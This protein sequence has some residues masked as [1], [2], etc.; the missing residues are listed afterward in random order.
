MS[1]YALTIF[2]SVTSVLALPVLPGE[3]VPFSPA[4]PGDVRSPC[5]LLNAIANHGF[6]PHD[7]KNIDLT[8]ML[9]GIDNAVGLQAT[10]RTFFANSFNRIA[11]VSSTGKNTTINLNDLSVHNVIE[12]DG[13]LS[14]LDIAQ[15]DHVSFSQTTF[16]ET[17]S[18]WPAEKISIKD[19]GTAVKRRQQTQTRANPQYNLSPALLNTTVAQS[20]LYLGLFGNF[21]D[22]NADKAQTVF[23]FGTV[24]LSTP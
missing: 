19:A 7:G 24:S 22:G 6:I 9:D 3:D 23:F 10:G 20:A 1:A 16:D 5:P 17:K 21:V 14:R 12:H 4:G 2:L 8:T 15:G 13:S 11:A 18:F